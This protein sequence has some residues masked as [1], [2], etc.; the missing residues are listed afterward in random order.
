[1]PSSSRALPLPLSVFGGGATVFGG[2]SSI[3][4][5]IRSSNVGGGGCPIRSRH[6]PQIRWPHRR[7]HTLSAPSWLSIN[8]LSHEAHTNVGTIGCIS[9]LLVEEDEASRSMIS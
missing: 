6:P 7:P 8:C 3:N 5:P 9:E 2:T 1:M 4:K